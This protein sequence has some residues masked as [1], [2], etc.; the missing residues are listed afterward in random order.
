MRPRGGGK[1]GRGPVCC[2]PIAPPPW[3]SSPPSAA[4]GRLWLA[5]RCLRCAPVSAYPP[6]LRR[7]AARACSRAAFRAW[8]CPMRASCANDLMASTPIFLRTATGSARVSK[9]VWISGLGTMPRLPPPFTMAT[10]AAFRA[11]CAQSKSCR[12]S[13]VFMT[14][15]SAWLVIPTNR[16][17][18]CSFSLNTRSS[19][20]PLASICARSSGV[21]SA[22]ICNRSRRST[23]KALRLSSTR[24]WDC[25]P[26]RLLSLPARK[27]PSRRPLRAIPTRRSARRSF[28]YSPAVSM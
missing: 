10:L 19:T 28:P 22:W 16:A 3:P 14:A 15:G 26:S 4:A 13:A 12:S 9:L 6:L 25:A 1:R 27:I 23:C 11:I 5:A 18:V 21:V 7:P 24:R 8:P 17:S 20:P 2:F